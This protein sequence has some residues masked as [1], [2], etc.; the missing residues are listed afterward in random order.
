MSTIQLKDLLRKILTMSN[1]CV[2]CKYNKND[3]CA[4]GLSPKGSY[5]KKE[6]CKRK[7]TLLKKEIK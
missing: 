2:D 4:K 1:L 3:S 6:Y 7:I 5:S